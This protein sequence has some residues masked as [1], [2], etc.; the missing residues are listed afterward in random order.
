MHRLITQKKCI[1]S[2]AHA[3]L[4]CFV[5]DRNKRT[6]INRELQLM[7][8][9]SRVIMQ[10]IGFAGKVTKCRNKAV[11]EVMSDNHYRSVIMCYWLLHYTHA[12][13]GYI[14]FRKSD[15]T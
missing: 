15:I 9:F 13:I 1:I 10:L 11:S 8:V 5:I 6:L 4:V 12:T 14:V 2:V 3:A 7:Q